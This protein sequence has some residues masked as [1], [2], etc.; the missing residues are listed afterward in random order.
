MKKWYLRLPYKKGLL[1][2]T[3]VDVFEAW[4]FDKFLVART[5][6]RNL[7]I[8]IKTAVIQYVIEL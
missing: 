2:K 8:K 6:R 5:V 7:R 3:E 1:I 4:E